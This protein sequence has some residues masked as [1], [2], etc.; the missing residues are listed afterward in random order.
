MWIKTLTLLVD[1][2]LWIQ[3]SVLHCSYAKAALE[4]HY[5]Q[6]QDGSPRAILMIQGGPN[7]HNKMT[8]TKVSPF[9]SKEVAKKDDE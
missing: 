6:A 5:C 2:G 1:Q 3:V 8:Y 9:S 4:P 7:G